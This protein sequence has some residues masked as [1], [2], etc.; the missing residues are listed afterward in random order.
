M[1]CQKCGKEVECD[2]N[3]CPYCG[4]ILKKTIID[5]DN[6]VNNSNEVVGYRGL[7]RYP[8]ETIKASYYYLF[9]TSDK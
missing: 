4:R 9:H 3:Y 7:N 6:S 8:R 1:I 2:V 5:D